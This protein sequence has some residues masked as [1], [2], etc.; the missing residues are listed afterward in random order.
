MQFWHENTFG[1]GV[2]EIIKCDLCAIF[3]VRSRSY[4]K[5][6]IA[7]TVHPDYYNP[8]TYYIFF[9]IG[10]VLSFKKMKYIRG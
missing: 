5:L 7:T 3:R 8:D 9:E 10:T 2:V 6:I 1:L 4:L